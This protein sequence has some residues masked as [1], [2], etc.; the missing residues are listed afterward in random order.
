M[1]GVVVRR[2][3][4]LGVRLWGPFLLLALVSL[5]VGSVALYTTYTDQRRYVFSLQEEVAA[6]TSVYMSDY[7]HGIENSLIAGTQTLSFAGDD[8][9][10]QQHYLR[11]L[12]EANPAF[13]ELALI[14]LDGRETA[15]AARDRPEADQ[16]LLDQSDTEKFL[17]ANQGQYY[18]GSVYVSEFGVP[19]Y[20]LTVPVYNDASR[21]VGVLAAEVN[22]DEMWNVVDHILVGQAGYVYLVDGMGNLIAY[23]D[24]ELVMQRPNV[25]QRVVGVQR[26]LA[27]DSQVMEYQGLDG[28]PVIGA[29]QRIPGTD[30]GVIA[31]LPVRE[32]YHTANLFALTSVLVF[33]VVVAVALVMGWFI[34]RRVVQPL[35]ALCK[36][37]AI[38][39]RGNLDY[40]IQVNARGEIGELAAEFN[41]MAASL[42]QSQAETQARL[43]EVSSLVEA[44]RAITS[45]DL[46]CV[47]DTLAK[48][49]ARAVAAQACV[50]YIVN[51]LSLTLEPKSAWCQPGFEC[52]PPPQPVG[53]GVAGWI[54]KHAQ[55][56]CVEDVQADPRFA[57]QDVVFPHRSLMG[58]PMM[59]SGRLVGVLLVSGKLN[60]GHSFI[61]SDEPLL[62]AF[63]DQAA[64]IIENAEL[65]GEERR[66]SRELA[67]VNR[68]SR[69][70]TASLDLETTLDAILASVRDLL[71][72]VAAE[73]CLW[74]P[75]KERLFP[76]G[77]GGDPDYRHLDAGV[78]A[79]DEGY[80]G[81]IARH[82]KPLFIPDISAFDEVRPKLASTQVLAG[83]YIGVPLMVGDT[84]VGTLELISHEASPYKPQ[85]LDTLQTVANQAAAAIQNARLFAVTERKM[86][87]VS[88]LYETAS[89]LS[90]KLSVDELLNDLEQRMSLALE[91]D[92]CAISEWDEASGMLRTRERRPYPVADFPATAEVLRSQQPKTVTV[93]DPG[94]DPAEVTLLKELG[95]Q[96]L[97]MLPLLMRDAV[98]GLVEIFDVKER[99]FTHEEI[100]LALALTGQ[101]A[102]ALQN[103]QLFSLTDE[104]LHKRIKELSGLQRVSQELN[105]TLD[106]DRILQ[107][108][109][110]EAVRAT[111]ADFGNVSLHDRSSGRLLAYVSFGF[112]EKEKTRLRE[113]E[114]Y[115]ATGVMGRALQTGE[116]VLVP[117]VS[118]DP[119]Y[120]M[121]SDESRSEVAVPIFY[122]GDVAGVINLESRQLN[123][124]SE[125]QLQYLQALANQ[126]AVATRNA[127]AYE[128]QRQQRELLRQRAEQLA[129]LSEISRAFRSDQPLESVLED[130]A[131]AIQETLGFNVVLISV[132]SGDSPVL[133]R[134]AGAGIPLVELGRLKASSQSPEVV[135]DLMQDRFRLGLQ[136]YYIPHTYK[137]LW[138]DRLDAH[139]TPPEH[140]P[141]S[142]EQC[143]DADDLCFSPLYNSEHQL[144]GVISVD[145]PR[146]GRVPTRQVMETLE[147]FANQ[148][149][150]AIENAYLFHSEQ[151]RRRLA[152]TLREVA[153][154]VNS[155]LSVDQVIEAILD[156][157]RHVVPYDSATVQVLSGDHLIITG[158]RGWDNIEDVLGLAFPLAGDNPNAVVV[159]TRAP[160][161]VPDTQA[162]HAAFREP[163][164]QHI[165]SWLGIPLLFGDDLLG[166]IAL[167]S[168][169]LDHYTQEHAQ[170]ALTFAN[171]VAVALQNAQLFEQARHYADQLR[172]INEVGVEITL[173]LNVDQLIARISQLVEDNFG[174]HASIGLIEDDYLVLRSRGDHGNGGDGRDVYSETYRLKVG[175][176]GITGWAAAS[177][178]TMVVPDISQD[179]HYLADPQQERG[180]GRG[181]TR[182][183]VA[184]PLKV[185]DRIIGVFDVQSDV[186]EGF[187]ENDV[188]VLQSLANQVAVAITNAQLF[189]H[190][191]QLGQELEQRV[192]ERT[193]ALAKT[194]E[195]LTLE[196][197][198]VET[199]YRI[200][201][202]LSASLDLDRVLAEA[203]SLINRAVGVSHGSIMLLDSGTGNLIYRAA[204]GRSKGLP[205]GGILTR[206]RRGV[207]LAGW[208]LE[209]RESIIVP[210][211]TQDPRWIPDEKKP[212]PE[213]KSAIAVPLT[214]G[215]DVLGV[216]LLFHPEVGYFT[217]DHLKLVSAAAIQ[218]ATAINNAELYQLITDQAERLGLMLR[219]QKAEAAKHQAI[220]EGIADGVLVLDTNRYVVLM[221]PAAARIL[222]VKDA[223]A[224]EGQHIRE[225][226]KLAGAPV[227]QVLARQLYDKLMTGIEHFSTLEAS[228]EGP[229]P[230]L[231]FRLEA[232]EKVIVVSLSPVSLGSGE[233][234]S[235][236]TVLR[237]ISRE[238]EV[239]RLKNEFIST[240]SHELRTPMTSIKGYTDLLVSENV[241]TLNE[242]QRRFVHVIKSNADRLT[243]L[244][245]DIL[246]ISR[247]ET[248]RIKLKVTSINL[249]RLIDDMADN[250]RGRMV[251][252][253][254]ELILDLPSTLPLIRG[255]ETRVV[256][257]LENLA[258]NAWK[259]T[260]EGG[261]VTVKAR[262]V[263]G[264]VQVDVADTGIGIAQRDLAHIFDRFYRTEQAE[265]RAVDGTGLGL[266]IVKM[267]VELL[268]GKI[269]VQSEVNRGSTFS[270]TL[271]LAVETPVG[272]S[273][274]DTTAPKILVVDDDEHILQLLRH[275]LETEGYQVLTAQRGEDVFKLAYSEQPALITLDIILADMDGFEVL[276][277]LKK[278]P[279]TTGIPVI[280]VSVV[281][282]AETRGLAL[283]AAGYIGKPF[284]ELQVLNQVRQVLASLG[285]T[286]N[287]R[288]N[289]V[290]VVDDDRH[291]VDWLKEALTNSGFVVQ[292][293]YNGHEAL[294]LAR[295]DS[296]DLIL[297]DLKMPDMDGYEVI[298][299][300]RREQ[301]TRSIPVIVITGSSFDD[302]YDHVEILG[303]GVEHMLTKPFSVETLVE[304]IKRVGHEAAG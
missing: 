44:G 122:A 10:A 24:L 52:D 146:D 237:D 26:F 193:E 25:S 285:I 170:L 198:R 67:L 186:T 203:L 162:A 91:A 38:L 110:E 18:V 303:M 273:N 214:A 131:Y 292:G 167:D 140:L 164:H 213:R 141:E 102:I 302:D 112:D 103:A 95:Y 219:T 14:D 107:L 6:R 209:T 181:V 226:L 12:L 142:D 293:A 196:R 230:G 50:I 276:E 113:G 253:S 175:E 192:Q 108:V 65:Y 48:E 271:P 216:L 156:Q 58:L 28:Q 132:M 152:D 258:S 157:L 224:V 266:A 75:E 159:R 80:T 51:E 207:G 111:G 118:L 178:Q 243:A 191:S 62:Q 71:P 269:W 109:L 210:D 242:Q 172:V 189:E 90:P 145:N 36:G 147:L 98:T 84:F 45:L 245:N 115:V 149:A 8:P 298:R 134:V 42:Q 225:I 99:H 173:I 46:Q 37:A 15:K 267:F 241:G 206:Y 94:A 256:Q 283:G 212:T 81:W 183:E 20:S 195:D 76:G 4:R 97:L 78:Y 86:R 281:P 185:Q 257:I 120:V 222:G 300:L 188:L 239:E 223:S 248:G 288:L 194:L 163:P 124:F 215:E 272:S 233:L 144:I 30:W 254:L 177:G 165:R 220:V 154:V 161:I 89:A 2:L 11:S 153:A 105:S 85:D 130:I 259:Y 34:T 13:F 54:A 171:Q 127:L 280:I 53:E 236:V 64:V 238:A 129:R 187:T 235:L 88:I 57:G 179:P 63:A 148:A 294:A 227:D 100:R 32:A 39:G 295:E 137:E 296:P 304:E 155:T 73:I 202:E 27:G 229:V 49:A 93:S 66:R 286:E 205:R 104:R 133:H 201:R 260:P 41:A 40:R 252:K 96:S 200:T 289:H 190:V 123:A 70:I 43:R 21:I 282:D 29:R 217:P 275:H 77:W 60:G 55:I 19:F 211:V 7:L 247:I 23:R 151:E 284:E 3:G 139:Y 47:L 250:F 176:E 59:V 79:I 232:E 106:Q 31:E 82:Q 138:E 299:N 125:E 255:D 218:V 1:I 231:G 33:L 150:A 72:Y 263:D 168:V 208:V 143:W 240:V 92:E 268:G 17:T 69:T 264:F 87:E 128:E 184:I 5:V 234:P 119:D 160:Y 56:L 174:Y 16:D 169:D 221:N 182:S 74:D 270:F 116:P 290:L 278:D 249:A 251:E 35:V 83:S 101:A 68:I 158:G 61:S 262:V 121:G 136:S 279:V 117:D 180:P 114:L 274:G 297:L 291:I 199:L 135:M 287:G 9:T 246:D 204:L 301:A 277:K 197:D 244:V 166:M 265:V 228:E 261:K 22:A 126:A